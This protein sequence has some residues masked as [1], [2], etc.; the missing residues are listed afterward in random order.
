MK[1][2]PVFHRNRRHAATPL[3]SSELDVP[4]HKLTQLIRLSREVHIAQSHS[5]A[6]GRCSSLPLARRPG[7]ELALRGKLCAEQLR[8][9]T[10]DELDSLVSLLDDLEC[11][12]VLSCFF[13]RERDR[14]SDSNVSIN[15]CDHAHRVCVVVR[16]NDSRILR[17]WRRRRKTHIVVHLMEI[18]RQT[19]RSS[20]C[21]FL[22]LA[23]AEPAPPEAH[24]PALALTRACAAPGVASLRASA[25]VCARVRGAPLPNRSR[26]GFSC[27]RRGVCWGG[28][29]RRARLCVRV[30]A[31]VA[32]SGGCASRKARA[33]RRWR[34]GRRSIGSGSAAASSR[35]P[36]PRPRRTRSR[37]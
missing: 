2:M 27:V 25:C 19:R 33:P 6:S 15:G 16:L 37:R 30:R 3:R 9:V 13:S 32:A 21:S 18:R 1:A 5:S 4:H 35:A 11:V 17:R 34:A 22:S 20:R 26:V 14:H 24:S 31:C 36:R 10:L 23:R 12:V 28:L 7:A 8:V 29:F